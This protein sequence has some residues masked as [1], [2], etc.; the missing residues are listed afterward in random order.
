MYSAAGDGHI[1]VMNSQFQVVSEPQWCMLVSGSDGWEFVDGYAVLAKSE[2]MENSRGIGV[3]SFHPR[4]GVIDT[5]GNVVVPVE[6]DDLEYQ[7]GGVFTGTLAGQSVTI[8]LNDPAPADTSY[9]TWAAEEVQRAIADELVPLALQS[10]YTSAITRQEFCFLAVRTYEAYLGMLVGEYLAEQGAEIHSCPFS[11]TNN[12]DVILACGLGIVTGYG[13]DDIDLSEEY[14]GYV[15]YPYGEFRP[16]QTIT[17]Q[18]AAAMLARLAALMGVSATEAAPDYTDAA[19]IG[20]WAVESV[21]TVG[22]IRSSVSGN[23]VMQG[24][25]GG[26]FAPTKTYTRQ[27]SILT[28]VR[29]YEATLSSA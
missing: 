1:G 5:A 26:A 22:G 25:S 15:S 29:L 14:I 2:V 4:Y 10:S 21:Q 7:G 24:V 23:A 20:S 6:Y 13:N 12:I 8:D 19:D 27:E 28:M 16:D 9:D 11:D 18:E 17:R 3:L